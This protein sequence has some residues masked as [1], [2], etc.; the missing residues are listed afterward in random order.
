MQ[1]PTSNV[2]LEEQPA[3]PKKQETS[4]GLSLTELGLRARAENVLL[5]AGI[6]TVGDV[7]AA[8]EEGDEALT[9]LKGF[10]PRSLADLKERL[11]EQG[12]SL[13]VEAV[14]PLVSDS[15]CLNA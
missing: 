5:G 9:K 4:L 12:F 15:A 3:T 13:P 7:L 10:G 14:S 11:Q 2:Q 8:L 6:N 1:D